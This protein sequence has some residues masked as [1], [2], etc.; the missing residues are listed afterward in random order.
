MRIDLNIKDGKLGLWAVSNF[1]ISEFY[2]ELLRA[3]WPKNERGREIPPGNYV[4]L[5]HRKPDEKVICYMSNTPAE[6]RDHENFINMATGDILINGLGLGMCVQALLEKDSVKSITVIEKE[7]DVIALVGPSITDP[8]VTIINA[9]AFEFEPTEIYDYVWHDI[10]PDIHMNNLW[11]MERLYKK[12]S[13]FC[14]W[15]GAWALELCVK[16]LENGVLKLFERSTS[17]KNLYKNT[18]LVAA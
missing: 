15:Q 9:D 17:I 12:Y 6:I 16:W 3:T 18:P 8:R 7:P 14:A 4:R 13:N 10:W 1:T 5:L 11:D 2:S